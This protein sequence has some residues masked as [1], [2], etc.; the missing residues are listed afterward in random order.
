MYESFGKTAKY[1][2]IHLIAANSFRRVV[3]AWNG[4]ID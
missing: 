2:S 4:C 3:C 1:R